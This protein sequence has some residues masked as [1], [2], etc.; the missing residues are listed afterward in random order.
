MKWDFFGI[1]DQAEQ[2]ETRRSLAER[3][4]AQDLQFRS[5][6][7][8]EGIDLDVIE[9]TAKQE[10]EQEEQETKE[11]PGVA[12]VA[13][14]VLAGGAEDADMSPREV[15]GDWWSNEEGGFDIVKNITQGFYIDNV[16][17]V[18]TGMNNLVL[19]EVADSKLMLNI[20]GLQNY[21]PARPYVFTMSG[22][23]FRALKRE[24][25]AT[26]LPVIV[27]D[28]TEAGKFTRD[29][30]KVVSSLVSGKKVTDRML[31]SP[32]FKSVPPRAIELLEYTTPGA[33][34]SPL[35][36]MPYEERV[37]NMIAESVQDTPVEFVAPFFEWLQAD[38]ENSVAEERFK[39]LLESY[40]LDTAFRPVY[41]LL[42]GRKELIRAEL[43][44]KSVEEIA[45][46][47]QQ[48]MSRM[49]AT[50]IT[51]AEV[52][53]SRV[54]Q[55]KSAVQKVLNAKLEDPTILASPHTA[56]QIVNN[57]VHGDFKAIHPDSYS[58]YKVFNTK[59]MENEGA[60]EA[61][62]MFETLI[63][64]E[65]LTRVPDLKVPKGP[66]TFAEMDKAGIKLA[67][68]IQGNRI[69]NV[70][71]DT[72]QGMGVERDT[73]MEL[74][75]K[76]LND[77]AGL[78]VR[79]LAYRGVIA[80]MGAELQSLRHQI[81]KNPSSQ[82]LQGQFHN[83]LLQ[84]ED[85]LRVFGE[86]RRIPARTTTVQRIRIPDI[87]GAG[88][89]SRKEADDLA[90]ALEDSGMDTKKV[91]LMAELLGLGKTPMHTARLA[92]LGKETVME[93]GWRGLLEFYR[94]MLLASIKTHATNMISGFAETL[95]VPTARMVGS[96]VLRD[97]QAMQ[98]VGSHFVGLTHGFRPALSKMIESMVQERNILDPL[99]T[100]V[101]GLV[102][103]HGHAIAM[104]PLRNGSTMWHPYNWATAFVNGV[105]K[106]SRLSLRL[107]GGED[108]FFK[109]W[110]YRAQAY[111]K[112]VKDMPRG[113]NKKARDAYVSRE[114]DNYFDDMG[115]ATDED[116]KQYARKIT[117]TEELMQGSRSAKL[118]EL[119]KKIPL[120]QF[121]IPFIR[122]PTNI[123]VRFAERTPILGA[124]TK[125]TRE[126]L[127]SGDPNL[128]AQVIGNQAIGMALYGTALGYIM[129]GTVTGSGPIDPDRNRL[130]KAAGN[131]PYSIKTPWGWQSYNRLDPTFM[132]FVFM[133]SAYENGYKFNENKDD[134]ADIVMMGAVGF[135][136]AV[137]DRT[138]L[139]GLKQMFEMVQAALQGNT[140]R[141]GMAFAQMGANVIPSIIGQQYEIGQ[142]FGWYEGA[143]GFREAIQWQ[144]KFLRRVPQLTQYNAVK[145]NWI[146]GEPI[147][148][149]V[150]YNTGFPVSNKEPNPYIDEIVRM[151]RSID[152][153][154]TKIGNVELNGEQYAELSRLIGT[155]R[156]GEG[157][158]LL[159][160]LTKFM[161]DPEFGGPDPNRVYNE[162]YEDRR[163]A[164]VRAIM[165]AYKDAGRKT[166]LKSDP[167]LMQEFVEDKIN[168]ASVMSGGTQLFDLNERP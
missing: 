136:R 119:A 40:V 80:Q 44:G 11:K 141:V 159:E 124:F 95:I 60:A 2:D 10:V 5:Q 35:P 90:K 3:L 162:T 6:L 168:K 39:M 41:N 75:M 157:D 135:M 129:D 17:N 102:S 27:D 146:T 158:T 66:K 96:A 92:E 13:T 34:A 87:D 106:F 16:E 43:D 145:H 154:D 107:L 128:R 33:V 7:F 165:R 150:G 19:P 98:E 47:E 64:K 143:E 84:L 161:K 21:D 29:M 109:Q 59:Y 99:G 38:P 71:E 137:T 4:S 112:I 54:K 144:E 28:K 123:M 125:T 57:L 78:E 138:Y 1:M 74:M 132:P 110:N 120:F 55:T 42:K 88:N 76:D 83:A 72:A 82:I 58:G 118:Q 22:R 63:R 70:V 31:S 155:I 62:N 73:L 24:K 111:S 12:Q 152:P 77:L 61:L 8:K 166:L 85:S 49:L 97:K 48:A 163:I 142:H 52:P 127:E 104:E 116:L 23:E 81:Q 20:P 51:Q 133:T 167:A 134:Y 25:K 94:G 148:S 130:W 115:R 65:M 108:E 93:R 114:L 79:V 86:V 101:D 14:D 164:G 113:L 100:K 32:M 56:K 105:G 126:M 50:K 139:Q 149:P 131:E 147:V 15:K 37:S 156:N 153:P 121:F 122:T 69:L 91:T 117:F 103:P 140:D 53:L 68:T 9:E 30:S 26:Y 46:I 18:I 67:E 160:A 36:F 151:G 89:M 45:T